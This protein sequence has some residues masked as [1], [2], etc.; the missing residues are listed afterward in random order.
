MESHTVVVVVN[1]SI[2]LG[3]SGSTSYTG[4]SSSSSSTSNNNY[5]Y[6]MRMSDELGLDEMSLT[7]YEVEYLPF[8]TLLHDIGA[9]D[10]QIFYDLGCG[11]GK[12]LVAASL[13]GIRFMKCIGVEILP[14]LS[15]TAQS[16]VNTL[17][18]V[19]HLKSIAH[20]YH[21]HYRGNGVN[22]VGSISNRDLR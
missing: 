15:S 1:N 4:S 2:S 22:N 11:I 16:I 7:Y 10:G 5:N 3:G 6:Y 12:A 21:S 13:S 20:S 8:Q 19:Q 18:S 9:V 14:S 17:S